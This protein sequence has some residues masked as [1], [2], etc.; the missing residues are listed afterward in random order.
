MIGKDE[1]PCDL[2][3]S[4]CRWEAVCSLPFSPFSTPSQLSLCLLHFQ[5][6]ERA[7]RWQTHSTEIDHVMN[8]IFDKLLSACGHHRLESQA[9]SGEKKC[10][11]RHENGKLWGLSTEVHSHCPAHLSRSEISVGE[12]LWCGWECVCVW[13]C[14]HSCDATLLIVDDVWHWTVITSPP[15]SPLSPE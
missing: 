8:C 11:Q 9:L 5:I 7:L 4:R 1:I 6:V 13:V 15:F 12:G 10:L 3:C 2:H 14:A